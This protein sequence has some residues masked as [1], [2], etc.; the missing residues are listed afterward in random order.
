LTFDAA[1]NFL[2][3]VG[4]A[5]C[6]YWTVLGLRRVRRWTAAPRT[7]LPSAEPAECR[8]PIQGTPVQ[9]PASTEIPA[10]HVAVIAAAVAA[11][12]AGFKVVHIAEAAVGRDW[13]TEGRR[14]HQAS[15]QTS[16]R[17]R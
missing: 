8:S 1:I 4:T 16:R 2:A 13:V 5:C 14:A 15:H 11:L 3:L 7:V 9:L 10:D 12:G 17:P 6:V